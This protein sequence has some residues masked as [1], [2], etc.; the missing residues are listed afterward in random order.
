MN[1]SVNELI[2]NMET[3]QLFRVLWIDERNIIAYLIDVADQ[4]AFP[5]VKKIQ[6]LN[7]DIIQDH[8]IK[9][10]EDPMF[11][12]SDVDVNDRDMEIRNKAWTVIKEAV[13]QEP[14]IFNKDK[15][16]Q[17]VAEL[18]K[19][20]KVTNRLYINIY[21]VIGSG[22][23]RRMPYC[24][25]IIN[26]AGK[27]KKNLQK[28][29]NAVG[30]AI[31]RSIGINVDESTKKLFRVALE[32]YY[33]N[34]KKNNL[35]AAYK[36]MIKEFYAD[37]YYYEN[38]I[39]KIIISD[40][41]RLPTLRQ[42]RYW[43]S[44]EY[45]VQESII[46]RQ[47]RKKYEKDF[48]SVLGSSTAEVIGPGSRYQ[49]DAT[50]GDVYLISRYNPDWIIGRPVIYF[51][52]DVFSRMIVG[53]NI[54]L[55]GPSWSGAMM[56]LA[57][58][59]ADKQQ[60]C[61][62]HGIDIAKELWPVQHLPDVLLGDRGELE[63]MNAD[64][65]VAAFN[66]QVENAAPYR[67]DWKGIV[68]KQ[69][70][71]IQRKV[72]P[73]LPGYIDKDFRE[74]GARDYRLDA[75]LTIEQFTQLIIKQ[76]VYYNTKHYLRDYV[77]DEDM[78]RDDVQPTPLNLWNWGIRNRSGKLRY[79]PEETV[80][81]HLLPQGQATVTYRGIKFK[82]MY[83]SC[84]RA[85]K[86]SW[87]PTARQKGSWKVNVSYDPRNMSSVYLINDDLYSFSACHLLEHQKRYEGKTLDE[88][89]YLLGY[90]KLQHSQS[91]HQQLQKEV[92]FMSDAEALIKSATKEADQGQSKAISKSEKTKSIREHRRNV[93]LV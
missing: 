43:Y 36:M 90:E 87:F 30:Q 31:Y 15:R 8:L 45:T 27:E 52:V 38:G 28:V 53:L 12:R 19:T 20:H 24:R 63:G 81:L 89:Q 88:I 18:L 73:F 13:N 77:R 17:M 55:E 76:I 68:E 80:K 78:I 58:V 35:P 5:F 25:I 82:G 79:F 61:R 92:D 59:V 54:G 75:R 91:E 47:G 32:K 9:V 65:L 4:K 83:Y 10:K 37:D 3:N 40:E 50:V 14:D 34:S 44:K 11:L 6:E 23:K 26:P 71:T 7:D 60:F 39:K 85:L 49:I 2:E 33:L 57:N 42:F 51:V 72:K 86:E 29:R 93:E 48:R 64:H 1:F 22:E 21:G 67:A 46:A 56:A 69:F 41:S 62:E 66:I 84:E 74:R 16:G 70:D